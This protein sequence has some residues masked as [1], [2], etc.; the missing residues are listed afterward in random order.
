[1]FKIV[2]IGLFLFFAT[3]CFAQTDT[4][5]RKGQKGYVFICQYNYLYDYS[6]GHWRPVGFHDYF[7]PSDKSDMT[8][9]LDSTKTLTFSNGIRI[10]FFPGRYYF[11]KHATTFFV[12]SN[13]CYYN[14]TLYIVPVI[15]DFKEY[16]DNW[17]PVCEKNTYQIQVIGGSNLNFAVSSKAMIVRDTKKQVKK[18]K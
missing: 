7:F 8:Q 11:K 9:F 4:V 14:D 1:M 16:Q 5:L 3:T 2:I 6:G 13:D 10:D 17:P 15:M 12:R 18:I